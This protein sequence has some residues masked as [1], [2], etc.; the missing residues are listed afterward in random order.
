MFDRI[1]K[2]LD[3]PAWAM[4]ADSS[5]GASRLAY[6]PVSV[7]AATQGFSFA[8]AR[9]RKAFSV[10]GRVAGKRWRLELGP[11]SR[12]Y[13]VGEELRARADLGDDSELAVLVMSRGLKDMLQAQARG[14]PPHLR[15]PLAQ[16]VLGEELRWLAQYPELDWIGPSLTFW[17]RFAVMAPD[18]DQAIDWV[19]AQLVRQLVACP[20][21]SAE[22]EVPFVLL[23]LRGKVYL[24]MEYRPADLPTLQHAAGLFTVACEGAAAL[25]A[26]SAASRN[27]PAQARFALSTGQARR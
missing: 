14:L 1:R 24:R 6:A 9:A 4:P 23:L 26:R 11:A 7:W 13:I 2:F 16:P 18:R 12:S 10:T 5:A 15:Q 25:L 3:R 17:D 20:H 22:R 8:E 21:A 19:D 27:A